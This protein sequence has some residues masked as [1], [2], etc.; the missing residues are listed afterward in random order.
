MRKF[1]QTS[2]SLLMFARDASGRRLSAIRSVVA[3]ATA[4]SLLACA[5]PSITPR[6]SSGTPL[7]QSQQAPDLATPDKPTRELPRT[8]DPVVVHGI[9][10]ASGLCEHNR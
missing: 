8:Y 5:P 4:W 2:I 3:F 1:K 7:A 10:C 9:G 6:G